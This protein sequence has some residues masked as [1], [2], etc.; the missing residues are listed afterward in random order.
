MKRLK[1]RK[2]EKICLVKLCVNTTNIFVLLP[3]KI[4]IPTVFFMQMTIYKSQKQ[5]TCPSQLQS[6]GAGAQVLDAVVN[7]NT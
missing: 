7:V 4:I 2:H 6:P 3:L 1:E 5:S